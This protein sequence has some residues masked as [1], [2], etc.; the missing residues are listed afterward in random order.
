MPTQLS[1]VQ[2]T[3]KRVRGA[4]WTE[5][6]NAVQQSFG[7]LRSFQQHVEV[8]KVTLHGEDGSVEVN[9]TIEDMMKTL[10]NKLMGFEEKDVYNMDETALYW[11]RS[12]DH[13]LGTKQLRGTEKIQVS[14]DFVFKNPMLI[15]RKASS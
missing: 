15:C 10:Q 11:R 12:P 5:L 8:K 3:T 13:T 1:K 2:Q 14:L 7:K 4:K 9:D 6:G